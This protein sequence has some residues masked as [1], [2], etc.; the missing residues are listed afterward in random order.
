MSDNLSKITKILLIVLFVV[1]ILFTI[2]FY[3]GLSSI[4][5]MK[6]EEFNIIETTD[7]TSNSVTQVNNL[8][9][10]AANAMLDER[11]IA[12]KG[13]NALWYYEIKQ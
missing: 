12:P 2:K 8:N 1:A 6:A 7:S 13:D 10:S 4:E 9:Q 3:M 5:G 11:I